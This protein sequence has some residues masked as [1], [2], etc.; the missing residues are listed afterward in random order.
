MNPMDKIWNRLVHQA[1]QMKDDEKVEVPFGFSTRVVEQW[2]S[3]AKRRL[4]PSFES[5]LLFWGVRALPVAMFV[6][7]L[8]LASS[9]EFIPEAWGAGDL[10][11]D[12]SSSL[13]EAVP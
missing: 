13:P 4:E 12:L 9:W 5:L 2:K 1:R 11:G 6:M 8:S 3:G 10:W 7:C